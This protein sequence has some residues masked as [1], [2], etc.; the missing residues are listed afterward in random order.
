MLK[1]FVEHDAVS[2]VAGWEAPS[3]SWDVPQGLRKQHYRGFYVGNMK[4]SMI[5][6]SAPVPRQ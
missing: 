2:G 6:E 1:K 4:L 5:L 3:M